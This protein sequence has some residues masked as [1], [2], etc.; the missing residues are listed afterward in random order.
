[1]SFLAPLFLL[2]LLAAAI[3]IAIHLIRKEKPPKMVFS[4]LRF[5]K[6]TSKKMVLFQQIQQW[7]LMALRAGLIALL[8]F[9]FARPLFDSSLG[10]L[11]DAAPE[12][13]IIL[14]DASMSMHYA[15]RFE[16]AVEAAIDSIDDLGAGDEV[17]VIVF[18]SSAM[19]VRELDADLEGAR[20]FVRSLDGPGMESTNYIPLMR[21]ADDMLASS[22]RERK[23]VVL[24]SDFQANGL[25]GEDSGWQ[26]APGVVFNGV[27][28]GEGPSRNL[29][30]ADVRS[31]TQLIEGKSDYAVLARVR[32]AGTVHVD[33]AVVRLLI[34]GQEQARE[35]VSLS[36]A[37]EQVVRL[38]LSF[39]S[40]GSHRGEVQVSTD[41]FELDNRYYFTLD[42]TPKIKVL[43]LNGEPSDN[44][45]EDEAHWVSL[46]LAAP[47]ES[48]FTVST[49]NDDELTGASLEGVDVVL[50]L[51]G[52]SDLSTVQSAALS[53]FVEGGGSLFLAPGDRVNAERFNERLGTISPARLLNSHLPRGS[54]YLMIADMDRRHPIL[55]PL[56]S[57]WNMRFQGYWNTS[58]S[59]D[60]RVIMEFDSG[61]PAL[62][63]RRYGDGNVLLF[64][65]S[66]DT[67]WNGL[68][69]QGLFLP[70][71]HESLRYLAQPSGK[72]RAY[73]IGDV[74]DLSSIAVEA[75]SLSLST[76]AGETIGLDGEG[77]VYRARDIGFIEAVSAARS[78]VY[79]VNTMPQ[80]SILERVPVTS[81]QDLVTNPETK[82]VQSEEVKTA[83]LMS[84]IEGS[85][86]LWWWVLLLVIIILLV[87]TRLANTS[88]R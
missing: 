51:N 30:L 42:V 56:D 8:V 81:I 71:I 53:R 82:P 11:V 76:S 7:L 28:V 23:S 20:S 41:D 54:D 46:A 17:G 88:Y 24:V 40:A 48:S 29:F 10:E 35:R 16:R 84:T 57:E 32:S 21:L 75:A 70:F 12:S 63:E 47:E 34:D 55:L 14:L 86:R 19:R 58:A 67:E 15:D 69:L 9:A 45:F 52:G 74:I 1:M 59:P 6:T 80:E 22:R 36:D 26:L 85:Q 49:I 38:P 73:Q 64:S 39:D 79:A 33:E 43:V 2:G 78:E 31:P 5:L 37:S 83:E 50:F 18:G 13:R 60:A 87:E 61:A 4:T 72:E 44:W 3:P 66:L 68:P 65:S 25:E 27:D 77:M 62:V